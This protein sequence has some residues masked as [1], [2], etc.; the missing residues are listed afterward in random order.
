MVE[1]MDAVV[2]DLLNFIVCSREKTAKTNNIVK[3]YTAKFEDHSFV[4]RSP[5]I[6][7]SVV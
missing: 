4:T 7:F 2:D 5:H 1:V 3:F 6:A